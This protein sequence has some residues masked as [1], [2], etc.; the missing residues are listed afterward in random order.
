MSVRKPLNLRSFVS[1]VVGVAVVVDGAAALYMA[2]V[3]AASA[4]LVAVVAA[5]AL[6]QNYF[7]AWAGPGWYQVAGQPTPPNARILLRGPYA[8]NQACQYNLQ[9]NDDLA[10]YRC[11]QFNRRPD[12]NCLT[13]WNGSCAL[14]RPTE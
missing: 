1:R 7:S 3:L 4:A 14:D 2:R 8:D 10:D 13:A 9:P 12:A 5:P 6:A 11:L